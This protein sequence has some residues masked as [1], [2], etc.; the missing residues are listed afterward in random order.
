MGCCGRLCILIASLNSQFNVVSS[1][2]RASGFVEG[3]S[4]LKRFLGDVLR[5]QLG[6]IY[7]V[8]GQAIR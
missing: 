4:N 6:E 3:W 8:K 2:G 1:S 5:G 7:R